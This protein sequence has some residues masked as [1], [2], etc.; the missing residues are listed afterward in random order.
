MKVGDTSTEK[1]SHWKLS[2]KGITDAE[3]D[4][5][6]NN[7]EL[8]KTLTHLELNNNEF[9]DAGAK[10]I[11]PALGKNR[12]LTQIELNNNLIGDEG[13]KAIGAALEENPTLTALFLNGSF[14]TRGEITDNGATDIARALAKNVGITLFKMANQKI[15]DVGAKAM[16]EALKTNTTLT[17][18][19]LYDNQIGNDGAYEF[20]KSL[21]GGAPKKRKVT[22]KKNSELGFSFISNRI[23]AIKRGKQAKNN[24]VLVGWFIT[25]VNGKKIDSE[26]KKKEETEQDKEANAEKLTQE[27]A[28]KDNKEHKERVQKEV[29][30]AI[31]TAKKDE[32]ENLTIT[33]EYYE[34]NSTIKCLPLFLNEGISEEVKVDI[35]ETERRFL[36]GAPQ[37]QDDV[38]QQDI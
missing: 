14:F 31:E 2:D 17:E 38:A 4:I 7:L 33:F 20:F 1:H 35:I 29:K 27:Q 23:S 24:G 9:G 16:A 21:R 26:K 12:T 22:F 32:Q 15:T 8:N 28:R 6:F 25:H 10:K 30:L 34:K 11:C 13:A 3:C 37:E 36:L 18:L 19:V 5:I